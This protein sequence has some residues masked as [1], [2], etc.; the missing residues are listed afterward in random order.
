MHEVGPFSTATF[1]NQTIRVVAALNLSFRALDNP[2]LHKLL[3]LA[4]KCPSYQSLPFIASRRVF[5]HLQAFAEDGR[6][7][8]L[9]SFQ[10]K[11]GKISIALDCWTSPNRQSF[12]AVTGYEFI[13]N[14]TF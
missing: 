11:A 3:E 9:H 6:Q 4:R 7:R 14:L 12:L 10:K 8:A 13:L 2:E 5:G 1:I